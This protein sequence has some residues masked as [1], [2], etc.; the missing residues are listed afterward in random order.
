MYQWFKTSASV[1]RLSSLRAQS[2]I[3]QIS[4]LTLDFI[5]CYHDLNFTKQMDSLPR[6]F[7]SMHKLLGFGA[8]F[9]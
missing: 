5:Y 3:V 8:N 1:V 2:I 4:A 9:I 6:S 7:W